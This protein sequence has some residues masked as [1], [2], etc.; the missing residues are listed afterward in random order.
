ML[1]KIVIGIVVLLV[2]FGGG[3]LAIHVMSKNLVKDVVVSS[4]DLA[5]ISDGEYI[6]AISMEPVNAE[7]KVIVENSIIKDII[8]L[9]HE[10][11]LGE[12]GERVIENVIESQSL[13]VDTISGATASSTIILKAIENALLGK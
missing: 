13:E 4:V 5:S 12:K 9:K 7:V 10:H 3:R 6:G 2:I 1:K 8:I 11:G